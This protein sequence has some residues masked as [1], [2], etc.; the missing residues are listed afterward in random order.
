MKFASSSLR[1]SRSA[2]SLQPLAFSLYLVTLPILTV[3]AATAPPPDA[4]QHWAFQPP[5]VVSPPAVK[6]K[7]WAR[8][9]V[10][11]F[12]LAFSDTGMGQ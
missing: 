1:S 8:T 10:D 6:D 9:E 12:I 3:A 4:R 11:R 5:R 7:R 2:F